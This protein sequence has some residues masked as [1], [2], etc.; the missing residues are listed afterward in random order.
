MLKPR[1]GIAILNWQLDPRLGAGRRPAP[2]GV[3]RRFTHL[4]T[5]AVR[6]CLRT[7]TVAS[8]GRGRSQLPWCVRRNNQRACEKTHEK[9]RGCDPKS[10]PEGLV[11]GED[12][13]EGILRAIRGKTDSA[14]SLKILLPGSWNLVGRTQEL[15]QDRARSRIGFGEFQSG[16][17]IRFWGDVGNPPMQPSIR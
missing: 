9:G 4:H 8:A 1:S 7:M 5:C 2:R 17:V 11:A 10:P 3:L 16:L 12:A 13:H 15:A 14:G 6:A